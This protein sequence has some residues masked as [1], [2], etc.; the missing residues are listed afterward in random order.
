MFKPIP[1]IIL[2]AIFPG[3]IAAQDI[4]L[5]KT[6]DHL[7]TLSSD[8]FAGRGMDAEGGKMAQEYVAS[9]FDSLGLQQ[10]DGS[11]F[12][13]FNVI[14]PMKRNKKL[15]GR[16]VMGYLNAESD[17]WIIISSHHDHMGIVGDE[18][19]NGADDN[20]SGTAALFAL[21]EYFSKNPLPHNLI[22]IAFDG[23]ETGL[24]GSRNFV[25]N[26]PISKE[27]IIA[28]VNMDMIGRNDKSEI[29]LCGA[30]H[31]PD[32][33]ARFEEADEQVDIT[34]LLGH[35]G[36]DGKQDWTT[37]SDHGNFHRQGI[38]FVYIGEEDHED[39]H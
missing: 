25:D 3:F 30:T 19:F 35:D 31:Y 14:H 37:A 26:L 16:N 27:K 5:D 36:A 6:L 15:H 29:Y 33:F 20:A 23:E 9:N 12:Q 13:E 39:Y 38:P 17:Q 28:N 32:L 18:V 2:F 21:A 7:R 8:S 11:W 24:L 1:A 10:F 22:F 4:N 34:V